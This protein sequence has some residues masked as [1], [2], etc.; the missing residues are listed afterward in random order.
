MTAPRWRLAAAAAV[1]A[2]A[3][4]CSTQL[5]PPV[6]SLENVQRLRAAGLMPMALG[7]FTLA[8]G[9]PAQVDKGISVRGLSVGSAQGGMA[10]YLKATLT[11]E[12]QAAGLLDPRSKAVILG[13]L[14]DSDVDAAIR[15]GTG[16]LAAR[17]TVRRDGREVWR[18]ELKV[19]ATWPSSFVGVEAASAAINE[20]GLLHRKLVAALLDDPE[21]RAALRP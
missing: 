6:A 13:E 17:F 5:G 12:L 19:S 4:G 21:F 14:T 16:R 15:E 20:Y 8:A 7:D 11:A 9:T 10:G 18:R 1:L 2:L 3:T